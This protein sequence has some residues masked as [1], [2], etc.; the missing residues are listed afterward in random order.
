MDINDFKGLTKY[1]VIIP[2]LYIFSWLSMLVGPVYFNKFYQIFCLAIIFY[3]SIKV[4]ILITIMIIVNVKSTI[5]FRKIKDFS[6]EEIEPSNI[7][8]L[9]P[10]DEI[11]YGFIIPNY[12]EDV[13][14]MSETL[15][16]L[17]THKRAKTNY[18][19]FLAME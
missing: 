10:T 11:Y 14:M 8:H 7:E 18:L 4:L 1:K 12:K 6:Q 3:S 16:V 17:A 13:E 19:I 2:A 15:D 9:D 5:A